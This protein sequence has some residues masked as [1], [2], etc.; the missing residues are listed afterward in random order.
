MIIQCLTVLLLVHVDKINHYDS[1]HVAQPQLT[2]YLV[3]CLEIYIKGV[4]LLIG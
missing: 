4:G 3:R 2:R 1:T